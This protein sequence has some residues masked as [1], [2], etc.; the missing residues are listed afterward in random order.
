M[1]SD[2]LEL[3]SWRVAA[4]NLPEHARN[5]IHTDAGARAAGFPRALVAGVT[6]YAYLC[7]PL[8]EAWGVDFFSNARAEVRFRSP[9]FVDDDVLCEP[10]PVTDEVVVGAMVDDVE[11][12]SCRASVD[13]SPPSAAPDG[14]QLRTRH[15]R[16]EGEFGDEYALRAGDD[17]ALCSEL[18]LVHPAVWPALA[19]HLV[20]TE[21]ARGSWIHTSST[22]RHHAVAH[23]GSTADVS[24]AVVRRFASPAGERAVLDVRIGIEGVA[25]ATL[26]HHAIIDVTRRSPPR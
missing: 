26:E 4:R 24:G 17:L 8:I 7:H 13:V 16:L 10:T 21:V 15:I 5:P 14:E 2:P 12:A 25:V 19:N 1:T 20:H 9:V 22:I 11:R 23:V 6:T 18:G 3:R